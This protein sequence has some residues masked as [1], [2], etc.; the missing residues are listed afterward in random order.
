VLCSR[1]SRL[2][3]PEAICAALFAFHFAIDAEVDAFLERGV[4][5]DALGW[6]D[7][8]WFRKVIA[9]L[10]RLTADFEHRASEIW[11][12]EPDDATRETRAFSQRQSLA[13][14][15]RATH[16]LTRSVE[17]EQ[18]NEAAEVAWGWRP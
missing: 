6:L 11:L 16:A 4:D 18:D 8:S 12:T 9:V 15:E 2:R 7:A 13:A 3:T 14:E 1:G 5:G 10:E 17:V